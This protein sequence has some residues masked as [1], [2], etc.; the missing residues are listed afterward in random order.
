MAQQYAN[1]YRWF[2]AF[3]RKLR[4][5]VPAFK[6]VGNP[7]LIQL[8]NDH[9]GGL[10]PAALIEPGGAEGVEST[11]KKTLNS[12][13]FSV[14][15]L[16]NNIPS[17][18]LDN[19]AEMEAGALLADIAN[20]FDGFEYGAAFNRVKLI[21]ELKPVYLEKNMAQFGLTFEF[22]FIP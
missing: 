7:A 19:C 1:F 2:P 16:V 13:T 4:A 6:Y 14:Y 12:K 9:I 15:V 18:D 22:D 21:N 3:V 10:L 20:C 17:E 5:D 11:K 8:K